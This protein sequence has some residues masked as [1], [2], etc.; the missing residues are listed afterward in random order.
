MIYEELDAAAPLSQGDIVDSCPLLFW[1]ISANQP[2]PQSATRPVRVVVM[3]QACDLAQS[4]AQRVVVATVHDAKQLVDRGILKANVIREQIRT[5]RVYGWYF[6][7]S[8]PAI[9]ESI[10]DFRDLHTVPR[11]LLERLVQQGKR[12]TRISTPF[13]EHLAQHFSTTYARVA[14]PEPYGTEP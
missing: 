2:E 9:Q 4:K 11:I 10:V 13:R 1:E 12:L 14:L 8:G 7:P 3:T 5:H 6:L